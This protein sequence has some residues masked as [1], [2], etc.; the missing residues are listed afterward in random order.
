MPNFY[1]ESI[2]NLC[3]WM[4]FLIN[5]LKLFDSSVRI[6][7]SRC[8]TTMPEQF[9][10]SIQICAIICQMCCEG[11]AKH[12]GAAF[13]YSSDQAQVIFYNGIDFSGCILFS[14]IAY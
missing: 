12:M 5:I 3:F 2:K 4:S 6:N 9:L 1:P 11:M 14:F 7:L 8:Q 10:Y 13:F